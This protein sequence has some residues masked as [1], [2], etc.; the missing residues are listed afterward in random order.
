MRLAFSG[1]GE[2]PCMVRLS[3]CGSGSALLS[4]FSRYL[5]EAEVFNGFT[6]IGFVYN[7]RI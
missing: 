6:W 3:G 5:D 7:P 1:L 4:F 2:V